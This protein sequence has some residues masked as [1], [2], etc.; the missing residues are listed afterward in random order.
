[1]VCA[2]L[3]DLGFIGIVL[4]PIGHY[5]MGFQG[6][7]AVKV[8]AAVL[9]SIGGRF[10]IETL[11]LAGPRHGEVLLKVAA[12]GVCHSDRHLVTGATKHPLPVVAGHE[13]AGIV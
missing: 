10:E 7:I 6:D 13:G 5:S 11:D 8:K 12:T 2:G 9:E 4:S 3:S 1:M